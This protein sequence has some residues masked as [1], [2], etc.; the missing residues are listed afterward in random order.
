MLFGGHEKVEVKCRPTQRASPPVNLYITE[1]WV[2]VVGHGTIEGQ[3][4]ERGSGHWKRVNLPSCAA[5]HFRGKK[6]IK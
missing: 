3:L 4:K 1:L 2:P 6:M 5:R